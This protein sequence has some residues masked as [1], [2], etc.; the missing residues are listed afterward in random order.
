MSRSLTRT[1]RRGRSRGRKGVKGRSAQSQFKL[2]RPK[3]SVVNALQPVIETKKFCGYTNGIVPGPQEQSLSTTSIS[4]VIVPNA[5]MHMQPESAGT[6][7]QGSSISGNDIFS[8]Y[9]SMKIMV[10]YPTSSMAPANVQVRPVEL[11]WGWVRPL[12]LTKL[13][14]PNS[15]TVS[16][17]EI[18][19]NVVD[20]IGGD[21][22][23]Q[24]DSMIFKDR[25]RRSYNIIGRKKLYPNNNKSVFQDSW[26]PDLPSGYQQKGGPSPIMT[27]VNWPTQKKLEY[28][29]TDDS[30]SGG[31]GIPFAYPN[32][33]YI[34]FIIFHNPDATSYDENTTN[35][36]TGA[37][38]QRQVLIT[39]NSCHWFNDA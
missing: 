32:Q 8:R 16:Q 9:L 34:P 10:E 36:E 24:L 35:P 21:F 31:V 25:V 18:T 14:S 11:I 4:V 38:E 29:K 33:A 20:Q 15:G 26:V 17:G 6:V 23:S 22:D 30:G 39:T 28:S 27:S 13:T 2:R 1:P 37:V 12:N 3:A 19:Q 7:S 5:Y